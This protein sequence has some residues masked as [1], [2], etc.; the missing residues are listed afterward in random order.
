MKE[1][2][3]NQVHYCRSGSRNRVPYNTFASLI[4]N[5]GGDLHALKAF[6]YNKVDNMGE[7]KVDL[8]S[9]DYIHNH[10]IN[11]PD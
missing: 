8:T 5:D 3:P 9:K 7:T 4:V 2:N 11:Q 6:S 1:L 10:D